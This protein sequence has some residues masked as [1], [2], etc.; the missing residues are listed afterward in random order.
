MTYK[1]TLGHR[2]RM[3]TKESYNTTRSSV[4]AKEQPAI[5]DRVKM[6]TDETTSLTLIILR[7]PYTFNKSRARLKSKLCFW[8]DLQ[9]TSRGTFS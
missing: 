9:R 8:Q 1:D 6:T 3:Y 2:S 4:V 5:I 7:P